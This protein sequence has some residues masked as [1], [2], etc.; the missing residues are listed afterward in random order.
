MKIKVDK[1]ASSTK[2]IPLEKEVEISDKIE[3]EEGNLIAVKSFE[4]KSVYDQIELID[5]RMSKILKGDI[6][7]GV[8]GERKALKG[9]KGEVPKN[10]K[11]GDIV[12]VLNLG[13]I[14]GK[15]TSKNPNF[16][17]PLKAEV[18][19]AVV[20][21]GNQVNIKKNSI[22]WKDHLEGTS[23]IILISGTCM[24]SGKTTVACE[25]IHGFKQKGYKIVA[26]KLT[27]VSCL[28]DVNKMVD[29][30]AICAKIFTDAGLPSTTNVKNVV[31]A[32]KGILSELN[33]ENPDIIVVELGDGLLGGYGVDSIL[34]D[35]EIMN[36]VKIHIFC[37]NDPVGAYGGK[38]IFDKLGL[39]IGIV[40]G[41]TTDND[42]GIDFIQNELGVPAANAISSPEK[43]VSLISEVI[44]NAK[45]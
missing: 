35:T 8:L 26:A 16:G 15:C 14:L 1:I 37:A 23:P 30:G 4:E 33:K 24:E 32:S 25:I 17:N 2:N 3:S 43:L 12:N 40:S 21:N 27:G 39:K 7:V 20:N 38:I 11:V 18:L 6:I 29:Y 19:G 9:F 13:G 34:K 36:S 44:D 5:G 22:E 28:K 10:L 41:P 42:V 31:A 45:D